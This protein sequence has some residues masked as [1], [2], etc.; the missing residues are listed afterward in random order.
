MNEFD[1]LGIDAQIH[2]QFQTEL[3]GLGELEIRLTDLNRSL[4]ST[5]LRPRI[6]EVLENARVELF[7]KVERIKSQND[8]H[9][10]IAESVPLL[11]KYKDI[12]NVPMKIS[13]I[14][15]QVRNDKEKRGIVSQYIEI[16]KKHIHVAAE[17]PN[18]KRRNRVVCDNCLNRK[19]FE[20]VD[21]N[22]YVCVLCSA[23]QIV[24]HHASSYNDVDR[25]NISSKY[26]Y[27]RKVHF[28]DCMNQY[29]GK[30]NS[31]V[32]PIVYASLEKELFAHHLLLP[33]KNKFDNV[34]KEHISMFLKELGY[35]KHYENVHLIHYNMT[36][37]KPD[38]ISHLEDQLLDD[39][40]ALTALYDKRFKHKISRKNFINTQYVLF[41]LL[42]RH[43]H[44]CNAEDFTILK[45]MDRKF[46]HDDICRVLFEEL[47]WNHL[48]SF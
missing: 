16:A 28:R 9:F 37:K 36:G 48:P 6:K 45:T 3:D 22:V 10:Y 11:Q 7:E 34:T 23:E 46:F 4:R 1:I 5:S 8:H 44:T 30:Q 26:M 35:I 18:R 21:G 31:T 42:K 47:G 15:R 40:D 19:E 29:Q 38:N 20:I 43:K 24:V 41:Q 27:D 33:G 12:L 25:V 32:Q 39:F 14:G 17:K 13:F 2:L